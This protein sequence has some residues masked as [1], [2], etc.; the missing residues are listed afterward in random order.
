MNQQQE[1]EYRTRP[2]PEKEPFWRRLLRFAITLALCFVFVYALTQFVLQ[3]NTVIGSSMFPTLEDKDEV[4]VEKISRLF[5]S[6]LKRGDIVTADS[7]RGFDDPH[8]IM[9]IKRIVGLPGERITIRGGFVYVDGQLLDEPYLEE[10]VMTSEHAKEYADLLLGDKEYYL[11]GDNRMNSRDSR[12]VGP[13]SRDDIEGKLFF[14][15]LPLE[16]IGKPR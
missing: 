2:S 11:L 8:E 6:G 10:G 7:F 15:F 1:Q 16:R 9:I 4:F 14:R 12:D 13:V 5:P 3:R